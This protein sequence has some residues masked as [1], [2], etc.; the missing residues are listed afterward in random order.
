MTIPLFPHFAAR[1][2]PFLV[3]RIPISSFLKFFTVL[4]PISIIVTAAPGCAF[5]DWLKT[6]EGQDA[7]TDLVE[8]IPAA[9]GA[10]MTGNWIGAIPLV[11]GPLAALVG[12]FFSRKKP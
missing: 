2:F 12:K 6:P 3:R 8:E 4:A 7:V 10:A 1:C 9:A 11:L 5:F